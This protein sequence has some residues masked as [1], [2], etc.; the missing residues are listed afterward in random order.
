MHSETTE[1]KSVKKIVFASL[2]KPIDDTR[3]YEKMAVPLAN[4][5]PEWQIYVIGRKPIKMPPDSQNI[6]LFPLENVGRGVFKR[7]KATLKYLKILLKVKPQVSISNSIEFQL[8]N[9]LNKILFGSKILYDIQ[10]NHWRNILY[11]R[12]YPTLFKIPLGLFV[13]FLEY[14]ISPFISH[15]LLAEKCYEKELTF[16][17]KR[18]T[19]LENKF[20]PPANWQF[21]NKTNIRISLQQP[22]IR[23]LY[24]GTIST[25]YGVFDAVAFV[26]ALQKIIPQITFYIV[27]YAAKNSEL[28]QLKTQIA[29]SSFIH[30]IGGSELVPH[31]VILAHI[32]QAHIGLLPYRINGSNQNRIPTKL[33]EYLAYQ[34]PMIISNN[35]IWEKVCEPYQA[36]IFTNFSKTNN[37]KHL[38][39]KISNTFF[40]T[41]KINFSNL[42]FDTNLLANI[43]TKI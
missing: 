28:Q 40:Y 26:Q 1:T 35:P 25:D 14:L 30:L 5:H 19:I 12:T 38:T 36:A 6:H 4:A 13:R 3:M 9:C 34:L 18:Y 42:V 10:E 11:L 17:G 2:L 8:V 23:L 29:H 7:I 33:Y 22:E 24:T 31:N 21:A 43:I 27:G 15:F 20:T 16:I 37:A 39:K 32:A 41:Q